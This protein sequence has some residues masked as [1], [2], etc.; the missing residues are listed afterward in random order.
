MQGATAL[1]V[2]VCLQS[3]GDPNYAVRQRATR[4]LSSAQAAGD[5]TPLLETVISGDDPEAARRAE[6]AWAAGMGFPRHPTLLDLPYDADLPE[7]EQAWAAVRCSHYPAAS[8]RGL[9][10]YVTLLG[11][12]LDRERVAATI[13]DGMR[14]WQT[15]L[16]ECN[17]IARAMRRRRAMW[18]VRRILAPYEHPAPWD[19]E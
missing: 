12:R 17:R 5:L 6:R 14:Q 19:E 9:R 11:R 4:F 18:R 10:L 13:R 8:R 7:L 2:L 3:L 16:E 1:A 15:L